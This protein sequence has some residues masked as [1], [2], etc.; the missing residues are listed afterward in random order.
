[1][2]SGIG[3]TA[4]LLGRKGVADDA[5]ELSWDPEPVAYHPE[6]GR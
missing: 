2:G 1:L 3:F 5:E 4:R 6:L